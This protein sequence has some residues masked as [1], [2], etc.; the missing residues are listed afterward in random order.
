MAQAPTKTTNAPSPA[1][2]V[3]GAAK[4]PAAPATPAEKVK[5]PKKELTP[6]QLALKAK[7]DEARKAFNAAVGKATK[8]RVQSTST[9][10]FTGREILTVVNAEGSGFSK[11]TDKALARQI[12]SG[13]PLADV[14]KLE[15]ADWMWVRRRLVR[16]AVKLDGMT[17]PEAFAR[18]K[19]APA[20]VAQV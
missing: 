15:G 4:A 11:D 19:N 13:R 1:S 8:T 17:I 2:T 18:A 14:L 5:A 6:E 7:M 20:P 9:G 10:G 3:Q 12:G 16:G